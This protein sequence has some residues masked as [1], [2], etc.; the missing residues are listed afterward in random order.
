MDTYLQ[1]VDCRSLVQAHARIGEVN[2]KQRIYYIFFASIENITSFV[3][4]D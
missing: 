1:I 4:W 3:A 2:T